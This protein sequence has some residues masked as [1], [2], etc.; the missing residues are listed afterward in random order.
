MNPSQIAY[1][2]ALGDWLAHYD[3]THFATF[4]SR[5]IPFTTTRIPGTGSRLAADR[6]NPRQSDPN[7]SLRLISPTTK[8]YRRR[9]AKYCE[10]VGPA[11][12]FWGTEAGPQTGRIHAHALIA[13]PPNS[14]ETSESLWRLGFRMFGRTHVEEFNPELGAVGYCSKYVTK[15]LAD[16][17]LW[18]HGNYV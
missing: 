11:R 13:L 8:M 4:T 18:T 2:R 6:V 14:F 16:Y 1:S 9:L 17:D 5:P 12:F 15:R 10:R 3:W 7:S